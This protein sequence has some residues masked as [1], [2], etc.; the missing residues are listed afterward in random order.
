MVSIDGTLD[1][2]I[3]V[4]ARE[5]GLGRRVL[6]AVAHFPTLSFLLRGRRLLANVPAMAA[7]LMAAEYGL[8]TAP[9]PFES[10]SFEVSLAWHARTD[11]DA[12]HAWFR[13]LVEEEVVKLS[14]APPHPVSIP[15]TDN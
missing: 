13:T 15:S 2:L 5:H 7:G 8:A 11:A 10:P 12:A 6:T 1:S 3:D 14:A 4:R 9:L